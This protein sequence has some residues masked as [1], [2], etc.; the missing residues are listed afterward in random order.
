MR[1][2]AVHKLV[3]RTVP[4]GHPMQSLSLA[5]EALLHVPALLV[6]LQDSFWNLF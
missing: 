6:V 1:K 3:L 5:V 4:Y 2:M